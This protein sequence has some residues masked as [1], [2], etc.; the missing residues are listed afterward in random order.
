MKYLH[1][2]LIV[3]ILAFL[4]NASAYDAK[5]ASDQDEVKRISLGYLIA[6]QQLKPELMKEVMHPQLAKRTSYFDRKSGKSKLHPTSYEQMI[7]FAES[8][9]KDGDKFPAKPNNKVFIL[10]MKG[11]MASV[12]LESDNWYEY[13]HLAKM[14][15]KWKILNLYWQRNQK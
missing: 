3:G 7:K 11:T 1:C 9:N 10:D 6:L 12:K 13:L 5:A 8:W 14:D 4:P 2:L 15:G